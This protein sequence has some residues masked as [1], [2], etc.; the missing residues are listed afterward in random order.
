MKMI[1]PTFRPELLHA[2]AQIELKTRRQIPAMLSGNFRSRFR[3]SGM[4]FKEFRPYEPGDDTRHI[5]WAVTARTGKTMVK[6][7]EQERELN[8]F[9][10][11]DTSGS[12]LFGFD[13]KRKIDM[14]AE[15]VSLIGLAALR[16]GDKVGFLFF[17][18]TPEVFYP[19]ARNRHQ[20]L[21]ALTRL[22]NQPMHRKQSNLGQSLDYLN[23][24]LKSRALIVVLSDFMVEDFRD[25]LRKLAWRNDIVLLHGFDDAE[26][27]Y[28]LEGL[29]RVADPETGELLVLDGSSTELKQQL[30][31]QHYHHTQKIESLCRDVR[32]DYL[33]LSVK[34][35]YLTRLVHFF[36]SRGPSR[37]G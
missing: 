19:A 36:R 30:S 17:N 18:D 22:L 15:V 12:S 32:A 34:D 13:Q 3:G 23:A 20:L 24:T 28:G 7:F 25:P 4:Q 9:L 21:K 26:R 5:S 2:V 31:L 33:P 10:V 37:V 11:V 16:S 29:Y 8:V 14:Y 27:G 1:Q 35:E 6:I